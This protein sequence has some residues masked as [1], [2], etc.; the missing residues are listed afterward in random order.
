MTGCTGE[1][2]GT[3]NLP[4]TALDKSRIQLTFPAPTGQYEVGTI[5][6]HLI[7]DARSDPFLETP[8]PREIMVT[9][10]YPARSS[11]RSRAPWMSS[12][13][14]AYYRSSLE[15]AL[16]G[17]NVIGGGGGGGVSCPDPLPDPIPPG[18]PEECLNS[19]GGGNSGD[20][21]GGDSSPT[22]APVSLAKVDFPVTHARQGA[23]V[24]QSGPYPLLIYSP[25]H[26][27]IREQGTALAEDLASHGY[28][29]ATI[30]PTYEGIGVE[31]P[32]GR[33]E[34]E[35]NENGRSELADCN[36][37]WGNT[38]IELRLR[39]ADAQ[40]VVDKLEAFVADGSNPDAE[41]RALPDG[42]R[43]S[44]NLD[45][46]G[47]FGHS[48][49][50]AVV[51][52]AMANDA[53]F[54]AGINL[55]GAVD[56]LL[57][58]VDTQPPAP[59]PGLTPDQQ[60]AFLDAFEANVVPIVASLAAQV[61]AGNRPFMT[62]STP[63]AGTPRPVPSQVG[64]GRSFVF[65]SNLSAFK[66]YVVV[67][68]TNHGSFV[69]AMWMFPQFAAAGLIPWTNTGDGRV[70]AE[71]AAGTI[72]AERGVGIIRTYVRSFFDRSLKDSDNHLLD[73][74]SAEYPEVTLYN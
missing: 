6:L 12:G 44:L 48:L 7:D 54:D 1:D 9:L 59:P 73:G 26:G 41:Q 5:S 49:G 29:V 21:G 46:I 2:G 22:Q 63:T 33:V 20:G 28:I 19:G 70:S 55:D 66:P 47:I 58:D 32:D 51:T 74:E 37:V 27:D 64:G 39:R 18:F 17:T 57:E 11:S 45:R 40:F 36:T 56:S 13:L 72:D 25:A 31:F 52:H 42:L 34:L 8:H 24:E 15:R 50:G 67:A 35:C 23:P 62:I 38:Q 16:S 43:T 69:D 4:T 3:A 71:S 65:H 60:R 68:G 61:S 53:R 14:L 30:S 10:W